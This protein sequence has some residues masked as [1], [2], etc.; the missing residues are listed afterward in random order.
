MDYSIEYN[1]F[2][3]RSTYISKSTQGKFRAEKAMIEK[4]VDYSGNHQPDYTAHF[5]WKISS[6]WLLGSFNSSTLLS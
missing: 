4:T 3:Q 5:N 6:S 2:C 1:L